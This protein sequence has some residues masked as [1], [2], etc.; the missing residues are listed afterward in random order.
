MD[1]NPFEIKR[2]ICCRY[3]YHVHNVTKSTFLWFSSDKI[4]Q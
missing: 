3:L 2:K 1:I 4:E